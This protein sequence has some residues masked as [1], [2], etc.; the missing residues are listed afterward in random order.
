MALYINMAC[1]LRIS[2]VHA[3]LRGWC[4]AGLLVPGMMPLLISSQLHGIV[5]VRPAT[6]YLVGDWCPT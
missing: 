3:F 6:I 5:H 2:K 1:V 4:R